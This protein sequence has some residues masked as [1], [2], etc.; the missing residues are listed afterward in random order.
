MILRIL[1]GVACEIVCSPLHFLPIIVIVNFWMFYGR[2]DFFFLFFVFSFRKCLWWSGT[3]KLTVRP[4]KQTFPQRRVVFQPSIFRC[5]LAVSFKEC[6]QLLVFQDPRFAKCI[7][8][9]DFFQSL[10]LK[11]Q[12]CWGIFAFPHITFVGFL[13]RGVFKGRG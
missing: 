1:R 5:K 11:C 3:L 6:M 2:A 10:P 7:F 8:F 4:W 12:G 9:I 13:R